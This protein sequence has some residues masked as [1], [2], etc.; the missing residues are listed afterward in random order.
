MGK[1]MIR[2][3]KWLEISLISKRCILSYQ[4]LNYKDNFIL[5]ENCYALFPLEKS[6]AIISTIWQIICK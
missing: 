2:V 6:A 1:N 4:R 5:K 3:K